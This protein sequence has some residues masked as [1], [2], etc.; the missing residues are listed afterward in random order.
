MLA[1]LE[2]VINQSIN[3]GYVDHLICIA[4]LL[5]VATVWWT[6]FAL[7]GYRDGA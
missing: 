4:H 7:K 5:T 2:T 1:G 6:L 3:P